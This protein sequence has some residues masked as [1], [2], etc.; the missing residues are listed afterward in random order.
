M[1]LACLLAAACDLSPTAPDAPVDRQVVL[2]PGQSASVPEA[3]VSIRFVEVLGDSRCPIDA[4][5]VQAGDAVVRIEVQPAR[6]S[7]VSYDLHTR[8]MRLARHGNLSLEIVELAP[9][10]Y[11]AR[12]TQPG[13]YRLTL[14]ITNH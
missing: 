7:R 11:S 3:S 10:P 2:A 8:D 14:R 12:P 5:C 9:Y 13:D 4:F 1:L 6:G